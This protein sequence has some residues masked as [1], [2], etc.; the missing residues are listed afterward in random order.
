MFPLTRPTVS[1]TEGTNEEIMARVKQGLT[2]LTQAILHIKTVSDSLHSNFVQHKA[3]QQQYQE[4]LSE[5]CMHSSL[6]PISANHDQ[7]CK[8]YQTLVCSVKN[9]RYQLENFEE[10][11]HGRIA[12][13]AITTH[14]IEMVKQ[15][16]VIS[17]FICAEPNHKYAAC[18]STNQATRNFVSKLLR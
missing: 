13:P 11:I 7:L 9:I 18:K 12:K 14:T 17:C 10:N 5:S 3:V 15:S 6:M 2:S 4:L 1:T 8:E 16:K